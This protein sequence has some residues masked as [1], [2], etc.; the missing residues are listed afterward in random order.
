MDDRT[1]ILTQILADT[2]AVWLP[3]RRWSRPRP[4]NVYF[5]RIAFGKGGVAWE[6]GEPTE[7]GRKAAQRE[8]EALAKAR[9][10]KASRPRRVKTLAVRLSDAAE[11]D[12]RERTGL[13]GLYS[14]W[15]SAGELARHSR[16]PPELV[17]DLYIGERKLI[18]DKPPGEYEREAV[19][20]ENM[21]LPALVRGYVDS[22]ADIQGRVSYMLTPAGWA[23]L[24]RGEAPPED[25]RDDTAL[26]RDAAEWY[27]ERQQAS[28]D[29]LDTADPPDPKEIGA[30]PLPVAIEGLRMSKPS[31]AS[32]A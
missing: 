5:A 6:S 18:G 10:V 30:I 12:T 4:A 11:A 3:N 24:N 20:V 14:A 16:R 13:P 29:R 25:L 26:D 7:A 28:L 32:V 27:A 9:L 8:L 17:T 2:D 31:A 21:L 1:R 19:V 23:W 22:N 15:L